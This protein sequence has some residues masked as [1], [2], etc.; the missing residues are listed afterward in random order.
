VSK[1]QAD[2]IATLVL[3]T[4]GLGAM[5]YGVSQ[6]SGPAAWCF[7]GAVALWISG[8]GRP[9]SRPAADPK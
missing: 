1:N 8:A 5:A 7:C 2:K 3:F 4:G 9:V 6:L